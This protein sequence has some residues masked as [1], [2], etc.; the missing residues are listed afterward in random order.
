MAIS[1]QREICVSWHQDKTK[2]IWEWLFRA[3]QPLTCSWNQWKSVKTL[4]L[5]DHWLSSC[6]RRTILNQLHHTLVEKYK[7]FKRMFCLKTE[8]VMNWTIQRQCQHHKAD[9]EYHLPSFQHVYRVQSVTADRLQLRTFPKTDQTILFLSSGCAIRE[10]K[11]IGINHT[12]V[13]ISLAKWCHVKFIMVE[14]KLEASKCSERSYT[15]DGLEKNQQKATAQDSYVKKIRM[16][17][18]TTTAMA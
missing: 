15:H 6:Q 11:T 13:L 3:T 17:P 18:L 2:L 9:L 8:T 1:E 12:M 4:T 14:R 7:S 10:W 5:M 16:R